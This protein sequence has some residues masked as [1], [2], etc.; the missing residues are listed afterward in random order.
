MYFNLTANSK[1]DL[2]KKYEELQQK[3]EELVSQKTEFMARIK[4]LEDKLQLGG[5]GGMSTDS[6]LSPQNK[7]QIQ[8]VILTYIRE[9]RSLKYILT[10]FNVISIRIN[11]FF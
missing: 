7:A 2:E 5:Q 1:P 4:N 10:I 6:A 11:V 8:K 9:L 3:N